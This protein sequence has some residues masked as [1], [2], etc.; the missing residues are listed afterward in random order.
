MADPNSSKSSF[1]II[2]VPPETY[3]LA[4]HAD[5]S[6]VHTLICRH[7][8]LLF[9]SSNVSLSPADDQALP[10]CVR[11]RA[12]GI[13]IVH[14]TNISNDIPATFIIRPEDSAYVIAAH[15]SRLYIVYENHSSGFAQFLTWNT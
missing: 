7:V 9:N 3:E 4:L 10:S 8:P 1:Y 5:W 2:F 11:W 13:E 6:A 15:P 12:I 14:M